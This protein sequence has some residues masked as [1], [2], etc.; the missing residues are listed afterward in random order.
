MKLFNS[1]ILT[2]IGL[3]IIAT[4]CNNTKS[5]ADYLKDERKAIDLLIAKNNFSILRDFPADSVFGENEFYKDP[6]TGVYFNIID[7]GDTIRPQW[8]EK[9][10]VRFKGLHYFKGDDTIRYSNYQSAR[11]EELEYIGPVSS[12]TRSGYANAGWAVPLSYVG[13]RGKV[14]LII[15]FEMGASYDQSQYEPTYYEQVEYRFDSQW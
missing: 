5:Y 12:I 14:K 3:L 7:L 2:L 1:I 4:S 6:N 8:R 11:P 10:Y 9:I 15:P 13:H